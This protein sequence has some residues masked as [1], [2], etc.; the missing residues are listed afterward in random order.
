MSLVLPLVLGLVLLHDLVPCRLLHLLLVVHLL[1]V[2][3][4]LVHPTQDLYIYI[5][6]CKQIHW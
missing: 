2:L 5:C 6:V 4:F 3:L 1:L